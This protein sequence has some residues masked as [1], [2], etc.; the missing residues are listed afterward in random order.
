MSKFRSLFG[1]R[2]PDTPP[3]PPITTRDDPE[4]EAARQRE[5]EAQRL[6]S[7]RRSQIL[8]SGAGD[9]APLG[10]SSRPA[11]RAAN[12]LGGG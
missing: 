2:L 7:G 6:R 9:T 10:S 1:G 4:I 5:R 8:T 12:L 3:L 11:A